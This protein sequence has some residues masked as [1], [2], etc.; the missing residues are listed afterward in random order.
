MTRNIKG[1]HNNT[2]FKLTTIFTT[3]IQSL[4]LSPFQQHFMS[5]F[6]EN[7]PRPNN[8]VQKNCSKNVGEIDTLLMI[9]FFSTKWMKVRKL[10]F[11]KTQEI[12]ADM[13][14]KLMFRKKNQKSAKIWIVLF[15]RMWFLNC[16]STYD[17]CHTLFVILNFK[18]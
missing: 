10:F 9:K 12:D 18:W 3:V 16:S 13:K 2:V 5:S 8:Y 15:S 4:N 7:F 11:M 14:N 17:N 6:Y 1:D